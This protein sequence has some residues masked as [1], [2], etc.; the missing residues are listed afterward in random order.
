MAKTKTAREYD[1]QF[2][3]ETHLNLPVQLIRYELQDI[4]DDDGKKYLELMDEISKVHDELSYLL[5]YVERYI[6]EVKSKTAKAVIVEE[7]LKIK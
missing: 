2:V 3:W 6:K 7:P 1:I 5:V 4:D